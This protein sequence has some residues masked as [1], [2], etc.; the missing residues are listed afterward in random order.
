MMIYYEVRWTPDGLMVLPKLLM[1]VHN[2]EGSSITRT[3]HQFPTAIIEYNCQFGVIYFTL[4]KYCQ[5]KLVSDKNRIFGRNWI[6]GFGT[7]SAETEHNSNLKSTTAQAKNTR[8]AMTK[9]FRWCDSVKNCGWKLSYG[10]NKIILA[11]T[12]TLVGHYLKLSS[13]SWL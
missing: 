4:K 7:V 8:Q 10:R 5:L 6:E 9:K 3:R 12:E 2:T 13:I 11:E 1:V